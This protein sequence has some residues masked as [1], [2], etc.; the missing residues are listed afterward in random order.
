MI[1][2]S[3]DKSAEISVATE[4]E[5]RHQ[6]PNLCTI[7]QENATETEKM[8]RWITAKGESFVDLETCR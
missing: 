3:Q 6:Q 8:T 1:D 4:V 7:Y 5:R 2:S